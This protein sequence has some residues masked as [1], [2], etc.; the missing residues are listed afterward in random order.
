MHLGPGSLKYYTAKPWVI[1]LTVL[2]LI[3]LGG[4]EIYLSAGI[5]ACG[6]AMGILYLSR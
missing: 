1:S 6:V 2:G 5:W 3:G 4:F